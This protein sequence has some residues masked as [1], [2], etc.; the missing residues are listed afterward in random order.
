[1]SASTA[2]KLSE[3]VCAAIEALL[4]DRPIASNRQTGVTY[5][6]RTTEDSRPSA[7]ADHRYP[8]EKRSD[9]LR[10]TDL[11]SNLCAGFSSSVDRSRACDEKKAGGSGKSACAG[12]VPGVGAGGADARDATKRPYRKI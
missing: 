6:K 2:G 5:R 11:A 12:G 10:I 8:I 1:L 9:N 7:N 4:F 3:P